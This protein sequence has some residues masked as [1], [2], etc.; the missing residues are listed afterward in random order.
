MNPKLKIQT[1]LK[2]PKELEWLLTV[3]SG[4]GKQ[5]VPGVSPFG[6][7][8]KKWY[9]Q[10]T[11]KAIQLLFLSFFSLDWL[12]WKKKGIIRA[13]PLVRVVVPIRRIWWWWWWWVPCRWWRQRP[14]RWRWGEWA[15]C[16]GHICIGDWP[17]E[18][19]PHTCNGL[20]WWCMGWVMG[21]NPMVSACHALMSLLPPPLAA[22]A[23]YIC[24]LWLQFAASAS[25]ASKCFR[26][27][28]YF[29]INSSNSFNRIY[30]N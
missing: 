13:Y 1:D 23:P 6:T 28:R 26:C 12:N 5:G 7:C 17:M 25:R 20:K 14:R 10:I 30:Q 9:G 3:A 19:C 22:A 29:Y 15:R 2:T 11:K 24:R 4:C 16:L 8:L 18:G 21:G 27:D